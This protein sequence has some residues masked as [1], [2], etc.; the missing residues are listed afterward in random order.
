VSLLAGLAAAA[1]LDELRAQRRAAVRSAALAK[2]VG[3]APFGLLVI[4]IDF[5]DARFDESPDLTGRLT[6]DE[7]GS[8][9]HFYDTASQGRTHLE[10][11][12][13]PVVS[14]AG[15]RVDYSDIGLQGYSRTRAM[16]AE[17]LAGAVERGVAFDD[18]DLDGDGEV[19][20]VLLLHAA[21]G[22]E[23][24]P[25]G[26]IVPL[27]YFLDEPV[28]QRGIIARSYAVGSQGSALGLWAHETGHLLGLDDRY[29]LLLPAGSESS[30]R[31]GLGRFS[32]MAVGW[33]GTGDGED[34]ALPDAYSR[35]QLGW[36]DLASSVETGVVRLRGSAPEGAS[37]Y[38]LVE[39]RGLAQDSPYD[40]GLRDDRLLAYRIREDIAEGQVD[41]SSAERTQRVQLVE[42][43]GGYEL[44]N[45]LSAGEDADLFPSFG[46]SQSFND[47]TIPS[48]R[49]TPGDESG[50]AALFTVAGGIPSVE[51]QSD[52]PAISVAL[53]FPDGGASGLIGPRARVVPGPVMPEIINIRLEALAPAWGTFGNG[54]LAV[55]FAMLRTDEDGWRNYACG[56]LVWWNPT[57]DPPDDASTRFVVTAISG[58]SGQETVDYPWYRDSAPLELDG[59]WNTHWQL[60]G[61]V[62]EHPWQRWET[63]P[64]WPASVGPMVVC[65]P[66]NAA[67]ADWPAVT[68][69]NGVAATLISP[70][71]GLDVSWVRL[72]HALDLETLRPGVSVD[73]ATLFWSSGQRRVLAEPADGWPGRCDSRAGHH[74]SGLPAFSFDDAL[75]ADDI[76]VWRTE[77][78]PV[79]DPETHGPGPWRL[80]AEFA[81]NPVWRGRGWMLRDVQAGFE[82][83]PAS[84]FGVAIVDGQLQWSAPLG[85]T[86]SHYD[87]AQRTDD[88]ETWNVIATVAGS[89]LTLPVV[90][91]QLPARTLN[92]IRVVAHDLQPVVSRTLLLAGPAGELQLHAPFPNPAG[93]EARIAVDG[94]GDPHATLAIYDLRGRRLRRWAVGSAPT[95]VSWAGRDESHKRVPAG[96]YIVR[97]EANGRTR[98]TKL[99][100]MH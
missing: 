45:G 40:G 18:A 32:L 44:A 41:G 100:W 96:V 81:S 73:A 23:N 52:L 13:S 91:L 64:G 1:D 88:V 46:T 68:Y 97:L 31:G 21:S 27:Q 86:P 6:A 67:A 9:V 42:A 49:F 55:E 48:S 43:D 61:D 66:A 74:L 69:G 83:T 71:L 99:T 77:V 20:G 51:D 54:S 16:A 17:A 12:L 39:R 63:V 72:T 59:Q 90:D 93:T 36:Q 14:L 22:L 98:T 3:G 26:F 89:E 82:A 80:Q 25:E 56:E 95:T 29:D 79:P 19:D 35:L 70:P 47:L 53:D 37:S 24:D 84:A 78:L 58:A 62:V 15:D 65:L 57:E 34:P 94:A 87:I 4:P 76:P 50:V 28:V 11:V 85:T 33:Q 2:T 92:R 5:A 38:Y 75:V 8:L 10:V 7:P 30:P 60:G